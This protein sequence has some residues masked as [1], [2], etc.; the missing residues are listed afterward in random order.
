MPK[1]SKRQL[2]MAV[3][4][5]QKF[6]RWLGVLLESWEHSN[7]CIPKDESIQLTECT[8]DGLERN[9]D[10]LIGHSSSTRLLTGGRRNSKI[11]GW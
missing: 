7:T 11:G 3:V 8:I 2:R 6:Q 4:D 5:A 9:T 10:G 1:H